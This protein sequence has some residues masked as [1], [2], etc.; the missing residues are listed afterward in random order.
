MPLL[1]ALSR[2]VGL[3][4]EQYDCWGL[5]RHVYRE[6]LGV[7]LPHDPLA[8]RRLMIET[9]LPAPLDVA[10]LRSRTGRHVALVVDR[11]RVLHSNE[12]TNACIARLDSR[13][14]T[15]YFRYPGARDPSRVL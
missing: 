11:N 1:S 9:P 14:V 4:Y 10:L 7:E 5:V 15:G 12:G 6:E 13:C 8:A 3:P 2:Y